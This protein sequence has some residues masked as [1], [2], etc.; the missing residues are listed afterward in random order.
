MKKLMLAFCALGLA[1]CDDTT[2]FADMAAVSNMDMAVADMAVPRTLDIP[3]G[4][5]PEGLYWD[6][7]AQALYIAND[8]GQQIIKLN[9]P[10]ETLT[11]FARLPT[12][13]PAQGSLGEIIKNKDGSFLVTRWG[14]GQAGAV[15]SVS[16]DGQTAAA[17][18][19]LDDVKARIGLAIAPDGTLFDTRMT[20]NKTG[21]VTN[22]AVATLTIDSS[23]AGTETEVVTGLGKPVG[24][25]V[26]GTNLLISDQKNGVIV[27]TPVA[28][29]G[30]VT[31]FATVPGADEMCAG[32]SGT[33]F[34]ASN[35]GTIYQ[36]AADGTAT[37]LKSGYHAL[38]GIAYDSDHKRLFFSE[39]Y[40]GMGDASPPA[41]MLHILA[42]D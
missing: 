22:G 19:G 32:P 35:T 11:V 30:T 2:S 23:G 24:L 17:I 1:A 40:A 34:A 21:P 4:F 18:P 10:G 26:V 33:I 37:M 7:T 39:P 41:P 28:T 13:P 27:Q 36:L 5:Q 8:A 29:P 31:N 3:L 9:E 12:I 20:Y 16:A 15:I 6:S 25:L 38:R 42:I 14:F